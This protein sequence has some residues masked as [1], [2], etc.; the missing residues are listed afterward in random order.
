MVSVVEKALCDQFE[1]LSRLTN[2]LAVALDRRL[3]RA[4]AR[5]AAIE[6]TRSLPATAP[7]QKH[8]RFAID[9][10]I[11]QKDGAR[12]I[13]GIASTASV[14]RVGDVVRP[15][16]CVWKLPIPLLNQH[17]HDQP[18]GRLESVHLA[19]NGIHITARVAEGVDTADKAWSL[20]QQGVLQSLS[21]G[22]RAIETKPLSTG[23]TEFVRFE[24]IELSVV[25]APANTD[26][27]LE[28]A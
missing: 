6:G 18:I 9:S 4:E 14:D 16:G 13:K 11:V 27:R 10:G 22:F 5:L 15:L 24:M 2:E 12:L 23:G 21:I 8:L 7:A 19:S 20:I 3:D 26:C 1:K 25:S 28:V 17:K